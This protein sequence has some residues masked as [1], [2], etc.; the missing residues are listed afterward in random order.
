MTRLDVAQLCNLPTGGI[1]A[2]INDDSVSEDMVAWL[3]VGWVKI[4]IVASGWED[5]SSAMLR[6]CEEPLG[7]R[8]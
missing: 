1:N 4:L 2:P 5:R 6:G 3:C 8:G 7:P